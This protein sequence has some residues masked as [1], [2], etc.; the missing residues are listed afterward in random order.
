MGNEC[1]CL[2][3][4]TSLCSEDLSRAGN[5]DGLKNYINNNPKQNLSNYPISEKYDPMSSQINTTNDINSNNSNQVNFNKKKRQN[6]GKNNNPKIINCNVNNNKNNNKKNSKNN[7][8]NNNKSNNNKSNKNSTKNNS[9]NSNNNS[10]INNNSTNYNYNNNLENKKSEEFQNSQKE[11]EDSKESEN[12][13]NE[14]CQKLNKYFLKIIKKKEYSRNIK[15]YKEEGDNLFNSCVQSIYSSNEIL[16]KAEKSCKIKYKKKGYKD[17]YP[18]I[19]P[20]EE[21]KMQYIPNKSKTIDN[22]III[23]YQNKE[24]FEPKINGINDITWIYKGQANINSKPNG[25][26]VKYVKN[27]IKEEGF[28]KD[29]QLTGWSQSIDCQGNILIG[30]FIEGKLTGKGIKYSFI[31][32]LLYKGDFAQSK[33]EGKGEEISN[34]GKFIGNFMNDKKNGEG[35]MIY[36]L[37]GDIYEG[38]YKD[39]LFDGKGHYIWKISGQE[40][41]GEYK[42]GL[43]HGKGLFEWSEGEFYRGSFVNGKREGNGEIHWANGRSFIG[44]FVNGR[45]QGIGI[46]DNGNYYKGEI[47]FKDGKL[48]RDYLSKKY[49]GSETNSIQSSL[50]K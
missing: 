41:T 9:N 20:E 45:P 26:G 16:S 34:E 19:T 30:P 50:E 28:W 27:G 15:K 2:N 18:K 49:R 43:M 11:N 22:S 46:F 29:G 33:K 8:K 10:S 12:D 6:K 39:D 44:P 23:N 47:E 48:N 5:D 32:N 40:Y 42:K 37:S 17:F 4:I 25:Y 35:K 31:N 1:S 3:N 13:L 24:Y 38:N 14:L 7:T 36:S 21:E